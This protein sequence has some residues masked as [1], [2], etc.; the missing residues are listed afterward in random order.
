MKYVAASFSKFNESMIEKTKQISC[1]GVIVMFY[2]TTEDIVC[3]AQEYHLI[4]SGQS[5]TNQPEDEW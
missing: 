4:C 3:F 1:L 2:E 5:L